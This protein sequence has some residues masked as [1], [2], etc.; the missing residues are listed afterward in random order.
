MDHTYLKQALELAQ[1]RQGFCAPNPSVGA[2]LVKDNMQLSFGYHLQAGSPHAEA[3]ALKDLPVEMTCGSTLYVTLEPC[4]HQ[5]KTPPCTELIIE[6]SIAR[7]VFGEADPNPNVHGDGRERLLANNIQCEQISLPE[8]SEF[9]RSYRYWLEHRKPFVTAKLAVSLDGKTASS[10]YKPLAI[11]GE[12]C[13][14]F[15]HQA[16]KRADILLTSV[17]TVNNDDPKLN[18]RLNDETI[19]KPLCVIDR[20]LNM[21]TNAQVIKTSSRLIV[22]YQTASEDKVRELEVMGIRCI[23]FTEETFTLQNFLLVLGGLGYHNVWLEAG[24]RMFTSFIESRLVNKAYLY[25]SLKTFR[26]D[27]VGLLDG[28]NLSQDSKKITWKQ[29]GQDAIAEINFEEA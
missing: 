20:K 1:M 12:E 5:G 29:A 28:F 9:Y 11:T 21:H 17:N 18:V 14:R 6:K 2:V 19:A 10:D 25:L 8:I 7:V 24:A 13:R 26:A 3:M 23:P 16:R 15:T 22:F 27:A 4:N